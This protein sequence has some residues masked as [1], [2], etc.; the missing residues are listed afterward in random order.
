MC[1]KNRFKKMLTIAMAFTTI[2]AVTIITSIIT[3][4]NSNADIPT[5]PIHH[6]LRPIPATL[7]RTINPEFKL[8]LKLTTPIK[9]G[10]IR[11]GSKIRKVQYQQFNS[12]Y[13]LIEGDILVALNAILNPNISDTPTGKD[14]YARWPG[15]IIPY[16][17]DPAMKNQQRVTDAIKHWESISP[18]RFVTANASHKA[19]VKFIDTDTGCW[20]MVGMTGGEQNVNLEAGCSKGNAI[21]E[22]GHAVGLWHE[23]SRNDRDSFINIFWN[24]ITEDKK[25]N[26]N[27]K[28]DS[29]FEGDDIGSYDYES[30]M[31]YGSYAFSKNGDA[32][33]LRKDGTTIAGQRNGLTL[34][35]MGKVR[36]MYKNYIH[37]DCLGINSNALELKFLNNRWTIVENGNH[38]AFSFEAS[39]KNEAEDS[40]QILRKYKIAQSCFVGRPGPSME[41]LLAAGNVAPQ[42]NLISNEDCI[43]FNN[44][45]VVVEILDN[46]NHY[47]IV[48]NNSILA[49]FGNKREEAYRSFRVIKDYKLTE[50]C[51]VGRPGPSFRYWKR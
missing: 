32:T 39:Q 43:Y 19:F 45:N 35:D 12:K 30:V 44:D 10:K 18:L 9:L 38:L 29:N 40:I 26:F 47:R 4:I 5:L 48:A 37:G 20:S 33:I 27:K 51:F 2:S 15:G 42:G 7:L 14:V 1:S 11:F 41:Y 24:N 6:P 21:H 13:A 17:I 23:Q 36:A 31:H 50:Q 8:A 16:K 49:D 3:S 46:G 34:A 28:E 22:I 25:H